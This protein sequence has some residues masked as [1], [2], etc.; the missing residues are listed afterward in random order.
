MKFRR[1]HPKREFINFFIFQTLVLFLMTQIKNTNKFAFSLLELSV[2][3][4]V[5]GIFIIAK[6]SSATQLSGSDLNDSNAIA[7]KKQVY[8]DCISD[9]KYLSCKDTL[10]KKPSSASGVYKI[11]PDGEGGLAAFDAYCDMTTDGGGWTLVLNYLHQGAANPNLNIRTTNTPLLGSTTL[12]VD[13]SASPT[14]WGHASN[15]LM[16][17]FTFTEL[18][19]YGKTSGHSRVIHLKPAH[20][21]V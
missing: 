12:G 18:R 13:E 7:G 19:L 3:I 10:T 11:D 8:Q 9:Y 1:F 14:L 15:S 2:V 4:I 6:R 17:K 16:S 5:V 20:L 21:A